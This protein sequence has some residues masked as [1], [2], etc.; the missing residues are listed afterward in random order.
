M[1]DIYDRLTG[2][3]VDVFDD[4]DL[5]AKPSLSAKDVPGWDSLAHVR[6]VLTVEREFSVKFSATEISSFKVVG[7]LAKAI[8]AKLS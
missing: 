3:L 7:D 6:F 8:E 5:V 2:I 4:D 1:N